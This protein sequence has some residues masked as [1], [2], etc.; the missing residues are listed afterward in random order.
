MGFKTKQR[1][2]R[3]ANGLG[4]SIERKVSLGSRPIDVFDLAVKLRMAKGHGFRF[5]QVGANDGVSD[6]PLRPFILAYGWTGVLLE[7]QPGPYAKLVENCK[8]I[9]GLELLNVALAE[10]DGTV[11]MYT[12]DGDECLGGIDD[13]SVKRRRGAKAVKKIE[14]PAIT[15]KTLLERCDVTEVDLLQVD[16]EGFDCR[17]IKLLL[18][19]GMKPAIIRFEHYNT[20][21]AELADCMA[22]L[23]ELEY[24][25]ARIGIDLLALQD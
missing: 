22:M 6:D 19:A 15:A 25:I 21:A 13:R 2:A 8:S 17:A 23:S 18:T 1:I 3:I 16:A 9:S 4:Y 5:V 20:S 10:V 7:P 24:R 14:V 12:A 11:T